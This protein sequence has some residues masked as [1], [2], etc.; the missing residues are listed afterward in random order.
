MQRVAIIGPGGAGKSVFAEALGRASGLPVY[1]L[2]R[3][4]WR[5]GWV[6]VDA[7]E[8]RA[9]QAELI[10]RPQWILDGNYGGTMEMRF[11]AADT[12]VF[13]DYSALTCV[14]GVVKRFV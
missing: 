5:P 1:H 4:Y 9:V 10:A 13:L 7:D 11:A 8:W 3:Y 2:D 6:R 12:V 14:I